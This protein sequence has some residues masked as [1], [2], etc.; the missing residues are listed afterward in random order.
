MNR[1]KCWFII[2]NHPYFQKGYLIYKYLFFQDV[3]IPPFF[4]VGLLPEVLIM[5]DRIFCLEIFSRCV[6]ELPISLS[7]KQS[8]FQGFNYPRFGVRAKSAVEC[9]RN[10]SDQ[11][12]TRPE[13]RKC[14]PSPLDQ[15]SYH[16]H[17]RR[18]I[19]L[20]KNA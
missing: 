18:S 14:K 8:R 1:I 4:M 3:N 10:T 11:N 13:P 17:G 15:K 12:T 2:G 16:P 19:S 6:D 5:H 9:E 7:E 20:E